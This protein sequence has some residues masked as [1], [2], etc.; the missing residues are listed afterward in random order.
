MRLHCF[1]EIAFAHSDHPALANRTELLHQQIGHPL[2]F[3]IP[4]ENRAD[5]CDAR[6]CD[7]A[8]NDRVEIRKV[9]PHVKGVPGEAGHPPGSLSFSFRKPAFAA[10]APGGIPP[11]PATARSRSCRRRSHPL[12][13]LGAIRSGS[14]LMRPL[15]LSQAVESFNSWNSW[16][17][18]SKNRREFHE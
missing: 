18:I 13:Q 5:G 17:V 2:D 11:S 14:Q 9:R 8:G 6:P 12:L 16:P 7:A 3:N 1:V 15:T 10:R 4:P